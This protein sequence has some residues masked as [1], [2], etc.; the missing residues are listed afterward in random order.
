MRKK[1]KTASPTIEIIKSSELTQKC[2][3]VCTYCGRDHSLG[4]KSG[5]ELI[6]KEGI[7]YVFER[8]GTDEYCICRACQRECDE[9]A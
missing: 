1:T 4:R 6:S 2:D 7:D 5:G 3:L 8:C 9:R